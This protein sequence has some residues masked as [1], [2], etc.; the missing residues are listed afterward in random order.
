VGASKWVESAKIEV[1]QYNDNA[2]E[3]MDHATPLTSFISHHHD[4]GMKL[5]EGDRL[6]TGRRFSCD[7]EFFY[8]YDPHSMDTTENRVNVAEGVGDGGPLQVGDR[9]AVFGCAQYSGWACHG[10][11]GE[12]WVEV[13][14][15]PE[16]V[17]KADQDTAEQA[18]AMVQFEH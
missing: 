2:P 15:E 14:W 9:I 8:R 3:D 6:F 17:R 12:L 10:S 5:S 1:D 18:D 7:H 11:I 4:V 16:E 13:Y